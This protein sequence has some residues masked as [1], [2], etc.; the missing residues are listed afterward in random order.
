MRG[1]RGK[2]FMSGLQPSYFV[3]VLTQRFGLGCYVVA[4]SALNGGIAAMPLVMNG[5]IA[6]MSLA[7]NGRLAASSLL[8]DGGLGE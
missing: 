4:P 5:G 3:G 1:C 6:A 2:H 7:M 8:V